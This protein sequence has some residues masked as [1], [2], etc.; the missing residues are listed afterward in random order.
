MMQ[1][2]VWIRPAIGG[3]ALLL[4]GVVLLAD[5]LDYQLRDRWLALVLLVPAGL[6]I[7]DAVRLLA[8]PDRVALIIV[9]RLL[10]G[11]VYAAIAI[12]L[13][14]GMSTSVVLP[15]L[16]ALLGLGAIVRAVLLR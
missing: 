13:F 7:V 9:S 1:K 12:L 10:V 5:A 3:A 11:V 4:V 2:L 16:V 14:L 6:V 8:R 15:S